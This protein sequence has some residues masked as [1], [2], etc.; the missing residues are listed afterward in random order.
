MVGK[1][2]TT[3]SSAR[4]A[5][6]GRPDEVAGLRAERD[7]DAELVHAPRGVVSSAATNNRPR[8]GLAS[9]KS[10]NAALT[11]ATGRSRESAPEPTAMFRAVNPAYW[12]KLVVHFFRS[13]YV[14]YWLTPLVLRRSR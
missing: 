10:K 14:V 4:L 9:K 3:D 13:R 8:A 12:L 1:G 7:A 5:G 6:G 11:T 2:A